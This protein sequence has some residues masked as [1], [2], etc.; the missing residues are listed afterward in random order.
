M[1]KTKPCC[2][3]VKKKWAKALRGLL[4]AVETATLTLGR[5]FSVDSIDSDGVKAYNAENERICAVFDLETASRQAA[6]FLFL[7]TR[8][9]KEKVHA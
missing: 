1:R 8:R 6:N 7:N 5:R 2:L 4:A 9:K 3:A